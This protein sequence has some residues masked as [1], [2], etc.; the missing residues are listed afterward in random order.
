MYCIV[1]YCTTRNPKPIAPVCVS[2]VKF[3]SNS[4]LRS[5]WVCLASQSCPQFV[6]HQSMINCV[7]A[8]LPSPDHLTRLLDVLVESA[9]CV[10]T[11]VS[12]INLSIF[13][14]YVC[15]HQGDTRQTNKQT[16]KNNNNKNNKRLKYKIYILTHPFIFFALILLKL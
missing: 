7:C 8:F 16:N 2:I 12:P 1:L 6:C 4:G 15:S 9:L 5:Q 3:R 10:V 13:Y 14:F 11:D